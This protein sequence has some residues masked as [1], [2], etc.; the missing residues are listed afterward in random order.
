MLDGFPHYYQLDVMDCG[1]ACLRMVAKYYGKNY[2]LQYLREHSYIDR[3]GVSLRGIVEA[4]EHIGL[5]SL[6]AQ[7]SFR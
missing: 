2:S 4:A 5:R 3:E 6:P 7:L 1:P